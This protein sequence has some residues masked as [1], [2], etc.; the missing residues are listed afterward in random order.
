M[1][2]PHAQPYI[3]LA[4]LPRA[5]IRAAWPAMGRDSLESRALS[6]QQQAKTCGRRHSPHPP[7]NL[8]ATA[9]CPVVGAKSTPPCFAHHFYVAHA[10]N[11][12]L[13]SFASFPS[14]TSDFGDILGFFLKPSDP[15]FLSVQ[16]RA[17]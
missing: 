12:R 9:G 2:I 3:S 4:A 1:K 6:A 5:S 15:I 17:L 7:G 13:P 14:H 8:G 11:I 16:T 10:T